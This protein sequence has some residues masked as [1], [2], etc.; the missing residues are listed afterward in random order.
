MTI[1]CRGTVFNVHS[2][3][4]CP[5]SQYLDLACNGLF[6]EAISRR[7]DLSEEDPEIL[8]IVIFH[9]YTDTLS[10]SIGPDFFL[11]NNNELPP[12]LS[13]RIALYK[14]AEYLSIEGLK[15]DIL[16]Q[17]VPCATARDDG[18]AHV[19]T[20]VYESTH[21]D[22]SYFALRGATNR[23]CF[24]HY[25]GTGN[26]DEAALRVGLEYEP[27]FWS[28]LAA[29]AGSL[30]PRVLDVNQARELAGFCWMKLRRHEWTD[31]GKAAVLHLM[32]WWDERLGE[33]CECQCKELLW[34]TTRIQQDGTCSFDLACSRASWCKSEKQRCIESEPTNTV[35]QARCSEV[36]EHGQSDLSHV[37]LENNPIVATASPP[38]ARQFLARGCKAAR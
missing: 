15:K 11:G 9:L 5:K 3:V 24:E 8:C 14:C 12:S 33:Q 18:I 7:I 29:F 16:E 23:M 30:P 35:V 38:R 10:P 1:V 20:S 26:V 21:P 4:I 32:V 6:A 17:A 2:K 36:R 31:D 22:D 13:T 19:L 34:L 27:A 37:F 28:M 25:I